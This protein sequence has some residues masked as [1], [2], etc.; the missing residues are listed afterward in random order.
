MENLVDFAL[1]E[2]YNPPPHQIRQPKREL[3]YTVL[4]FETED[5]K[6]YILGCLIILLYENGHQDQE[7]QWN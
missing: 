2:R 7:D 6:I 5:R 3:C 1:Q 4:K